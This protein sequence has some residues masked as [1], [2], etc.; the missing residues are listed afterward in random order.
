M[1]RLL[2]LLLLFL[3]MAVIFSQDDKPNI[4]VIYADD[5]GWGDLGC[6]GNRR[7]KTP[8]L[9]RLAGEGMMFTQFYVNSAVCSPSRAALM[10]GK[11]PAELRIH[12]HFANDESNG[13][14]GMV[15]FLDPEI[16]NYMNIL[17]S[18]GYATGHFGKWHLGSGITAPEPEA[19]GVDE[20]RVSAGNGPQFDFRVVYHKWPPRYY[21]G[22]EQPPPDPGNR[23]TSSE[24]IINEAISFIEKHKDERIA[25]NI[26]L[27]DVH[28]TLDPSEDQLE[29]YK[30]MMPGEL[31]DKYPGVNAVYAAAMTGADKQIGR[32]LDRLE[33]LGLEE[34][35]VVFF[36]TDNGPEDISL[37][38]TSHSAGG[39]TGPHRGRKRSLYEGG[40]RVPFI[41]RYPNVVMDGQINTGTVVSAVD[42]LP[43]ICDLIG[44]EIPDGTRGESMLDVLSGES[45]SRETD[46]FWEWRYGI[47]GHFMHFSPA[48]AM[49][50]GD[51]KLLMNPDYSRVELYNIVNDPGEMDNLADEMPE[52][53]KQM[54]DVL[55]TW[56][57]GNPEGPGKENCIQYTWEI[58]GLE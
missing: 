8:N 17:K 18:E 11:Y 41:V 30:R 36:A 7:I 9:D 3:N 48:L 43:T 6:Y 19:Y 45:R 34:N 50:S 20:Y 14:R 13:K 47:M 23:S 52:K 58:P 46:L 24:K 39:N 38:E 35:T 1:K 26:W 31:E 28:S 49:R 12:G 42:I 32:F 5:W 4:V 57:N 55:M 25:L 53:V 16:P 29:E 10:T 15:N 33:E 27:L 37:S 44:H 21:E 51:W 2:L 54:S 56:H 22:E 40:I